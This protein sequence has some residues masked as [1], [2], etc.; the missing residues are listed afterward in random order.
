VVGACFRGSEA[1]QGY[2]G[3]HGEVD[4]RVYYLIFKSGEK[5]VKNLAVS[6]SDLEVIHIMGHLGVIFVN[7]EDGFGVIFFVEGPNK[8]YPGG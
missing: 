1:V 3:K 5:V 8:Y 7:K 4:I 2:A 6:L